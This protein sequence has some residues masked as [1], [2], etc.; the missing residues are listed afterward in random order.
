[1]KSEIHPP[2]DGARHDLRIL[3]ALWGLFLPF[4]L[5]APNSYAVGLAV[6]FSINLMLIASLNLLMGYCG[7]ISMCQAGFFGLGAYVSGALSAK[8]GLPALASIPAALAIASTAA[9]LIA[10][11]VL[12]LRGHYLAMATLGFNAILSV[13]FV[14]LVDFTGGPNGLSG[15]EP[16]TIAGYAFDTDRRFFY[17]AWA[18]GLLLM[19]GFL[20]LT[21]SRIGRAMISVAGSEVG[22]ASLGINTYALKVAVFVLCAAVAAWRARFMSTST[23]SRRRK[24]SVSPRRCCCWSWSRSEA[25]AS[26]GDRCSARWSTPRCRNCCAPST[27]WSCCCSGWA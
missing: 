17:L 27:T 19:W 13:L 25:G 10:L 21:R 4:P 9:L 16:I 15:V 6:T 22:A 11:P 3:L 8:Y 5:V 1:M 2:G 12:R 24:P 26:T 18:A 23:S 20:N 14:E 7:Q